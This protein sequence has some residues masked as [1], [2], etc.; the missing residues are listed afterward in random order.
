MA[1]VFISY[2]RKDKEFVKVLHTALA[3]QQ[4]DTW[5]DWED[6]PLTA[7]WWQEIQ[8]GIEAADTFVFVISPDSVISKVCTQEIDHAVQNHK[9]LVPIV[10][11]DD[12]DANQVHPALRKHNW[13]FCRPTDDV[14]RA[15]KDLLTAIDTDLEYVH[16]HTRL[17][18]RAIEWEQSKRD[19]SFLLRGNDL[20]AADRWLNQG[21]DKEPKP[22]TLQTQYI[23]ASGKAE[24]QRQRQARMISTVGFIGAIG[25]ALIALTQYQQAKQRQLEAEKGQILA[26]SASANANLA[27]NQD[28]EALIAAIKL[29]QKLQQASNPDAETQ[30]TALSALQQVIYG[31]KEQNRLAGHNDY[32]S[33]ASFSP[34]G[35]TIATASDDKT[36]KLWRRDGTLLRTLKPNTCVT[37]VSFSPDNQ[38]LATAN[39]DET[40]Q[41]W[42]LEGK[43]LKTLKGHHD[44]LTSVVFS[45]DGQTL[46]SA[47]WDNTAKL[48]RRDGTLLQTFKG[49][50]GPIYQVALSP[51]GEFLATASGDRTI[52]VWKSD[53]SLIRTFRGHRDQVLSVSFSPDGQ[54]LASASADKTIKLWKS[55]GTLV[56]TLKGHSGSVYAIRFSPDGQ[57][58]ASGGDDANEKTI[59]L[60]NLDGTLLR[61]LK[62]HSGWVTNLSF[63]PD[64]QTLL[65]S[66]FDGTAKLW[67]LHSPLLTRLK[68]NKHGIYDVKFSSKSSL[69][70]TFYQESNSEAGISVLQPDGAL[71]KTIPL[72]QKIY[73]N[74][75]S[76]VDKLIALAT[77]DNQISLL[78]TDGKLLRTFP[79]LNNA[80]KLLQFSLDGQTLASFSYQD[81]TLRLWSLEGRLLH[82]FSGPIDWFDWATRLRVSP[83]LQK[84]I[85]LRGFDAKL[86]QRDGKLITILK[87]H[88]GTILDAS[89]SEDG[90]TIATSSFDKT[91]KLWTLDGKLITTLKGHTTSVTGVI[92]SP[93]GQRIVTYGEDSTIKIWK[94]DGTLVTTLKT[95]SPPSTVRFSSNGKTLAF[96]ANHT[97]YLWNT[98][99]LA[100][101]SALMVHGCTLLQDYLISHPKQL[102]ELDTCQNQAT[103]LPAG[104]TLAKLEDIPNAIKLFRQ[105][106]EQD[107][108]LKLDPEREAQRLATQGK[109]Q[110]L[111]E[112]GQDLALDENIPAA[113]TKF[114]E[115][116]KLDPIL[117]FDSIAEAKRLADQSKAF[118]LSDAGQALAM[119]GNT[120]EAVVKFREAVAINPD[121][122]YIPE[123][124]ARLFRAVGLKERVLP[125]VKQGK[126]T[127][128][129]ALLSQAEAILPVQDQFMFSETWNY[130]CSGGSVWN[131]AEMVMPFC[132]KAVAA[133]PDNGEYR[134]GRGIARAMT[135][136]PVNAIADFQ[137]FI[138]WTE[139][140]ERKALRQHW[141]KVLQA[142]ENP[143]TAEERKKLRDK[144]LGNSLT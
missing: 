124:E 33:D 22:T 95:D 137:A 5:V 89:F 98:G 130:F 105:A 45:P 18:V 122:P 19:S 101:T 20:K 53:G 58:L 29:G 60:W 80:V 77:D 2:S 142:G 102:L 143:F 17:L 49:H 70:F 65:S 136:D 135:G 16:A 120:A 131:Q 11:R 42:S 92:F 1:D 6:I 86:W 125:L 109:A 52:K 108:N 24:I 96:V 39:C 34:D 71:V 132:E 123:E 23:L 126:I 59:K 99:D 138:D 83:D 115:A 67:Q 81:R 44:W 72:R 12:F 90:R 140:D 79:Q 55:D 106:L 48:W 3:E 57:M 66:S 68:V 26:L 7:D 36:V 76:P 97:A 61:T 134:D 15:F 21:L 62:G 50:H 88:E 43:R 133:D 107:P 4:R 114:Q 78:H 30:A 87:G 56:R 37:S 32:M 127:E 93:D 73:A 28:I 84:V 74:E 41:L 104:R 116:V 38:T 35:Q 40:V 91:A 111:F 25:L 46:A 54:T 94:Q 141:V 113:V 9:R 110:R 51:N 144:E 64:N 75:I 128:A 112:E 118:R 63:S 129:I 13:L 82:S 121:L 69:L 10:R 85:T 31:V 117:S 100:S 47:S 103:L 8:R 14:D 119:S 139:D 27:S